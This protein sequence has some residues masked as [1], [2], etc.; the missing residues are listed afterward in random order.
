MIQYHVSEMYPK[1]MERT[2]NYK[3]PVTFKGNR[4]Q[5]TGRHVAALQYK[6]ILPVITN[7]FANEVVPEKQAKLGYRHHRHMGLYQSSAACVE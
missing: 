1:P 4:L 5:Q 6:R 3:T 7:C 2:E